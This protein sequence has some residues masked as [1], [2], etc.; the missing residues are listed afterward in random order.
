MTSNRLIT[1]LRE[2]TENQYT[3]SVLMMWLSNCH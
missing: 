1:L 2:L 3:D